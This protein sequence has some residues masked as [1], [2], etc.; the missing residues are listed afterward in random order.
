[1]KKT[2]VL[3]IS[4]VLLLSGCNGKPKEQTTTSA[5]SETEA[6]I[7]TE[8]TEEVTAETTETSATTVAEEQDENE[9]FTYI[10]G[11]TDFY[12]GY[13]SPEYVDRETLPVKG[14]TPYER[15]VIHSNVYAENYD[16]YLI[17]EEVTRSEDSSYIYAERFGIAV[18]NG[19]GIIESV[20]TLPESDRYSIPVDMEYNSF[21]YYRVQ[22]NGEEHYLYDVSLLADGIYERYFLA[23]K[24][25]E[26]FLFNDEP[27][28]MGKEY[29][30]ISEES[31]VTNEEKHIR[32]NLDF[33][34]VTYTEEPM[35]ITEPVPY[36]TAP[37][38]IGY[39]GYEALGFLT[40]EQNEIYIASRRLSTV[41]MD[42]SALRLPYGDYLSNEFSCITNVS[43]ESLRDYIG[44]VFTEESI[45]YVINPGMFLDVGG[46][47]FWRDGARGGNISF[48]HEEITLVSA[49]ENKIVM[50]CTAYYLND[51]DDEE[52]GYYTEEQEL[53]M[54]NT[55]NGWRMEYYPLWY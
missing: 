6:V 20:F 51:S 48:R 23:L 42:S 3:L 43:Y 12:Y 54:V 55:E 26:V 21:S 4:A 16:L 18:V 32:Y 7:V 41:Q 53:T 10:P 49:D 31:V 5:V 37:E 15:M 52:S 33:N 9:E 11:V 30:I 50:K 17:G 28:D 35:V 14:E 36:E 29:G 8:A 39:G 22:F 38:N 45:D 2:F 13:V 19:E 24:D 25:N 27:L 40:E 1:M 46:R 34:T 47:V 44:S